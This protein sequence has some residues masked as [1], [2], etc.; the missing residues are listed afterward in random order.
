VVTVSFS[1]SLPPR[2]DWSADDF[3]QARVV[4]AAGTTVVFEERGSTLNDGASFAARSVDLSAFAGQTIRLEFA[5]A[6]LATDQ[7]LEAA[8][9]DVK[10]VVR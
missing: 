2:N 9:D 10:I 6:D 3:F 7:L 4:T 5:A 8:V 1:Y